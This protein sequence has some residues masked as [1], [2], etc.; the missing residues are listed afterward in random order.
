M[1]KMAKT[2]EIGRTE[3]S[4]RNSSMALVSKIIAI[5]L[6]YFAR[7]VFTH[8]LSESYVSI[9]GLFLEIL[10]VLAI[11]ELGIGVSISYSLY[12]PIARGDVEKQKSLMQLYRRVYFGV[13]GLIVVFGGI[14]AAF[15]PRIVSDDIVVDRIY[16]IYFMYLADACL[17]YFLAYRKTIVEA[18]QKSYITVSIQ[19]FSFIIQNAVQMV[20]LFTTK[21]FILYLSIRLICTLAS[22]LTCS[23]YAV[24][25]YP[26]IK[27]KDVTPLS[28]D[29]KDD[30]FKNV[31]AMMVHKIG[32]VVVNNTDNIFLSVL[33]STLAVGSYSNYYLI[34]GSARQAIDQVLQGITASVG[35]LGHTESVEKMKKIF[36]TTFFVNQWLYSLATICMFNVLDEFVGFSFGN[37]YVFSRDI[38]LVLCLVF[39]IKG[40]RQACL[41]F[42]DSMGLFR[43]D[44]MKA[45]AEMIINVVA[46]L[47]LGKMFGTIGVFIGTIICT[48]TTSTWVEPYVLYKHKLKEGLAGYYLKWILY[49]GIMLA[50]LF[51][52]AKIC[53]LISLGGFGGIIIK[54]ILSFAITN[55]VFLL[56]YSKTREF[57]YCMTKAKGLVKTIFN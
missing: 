28:Q 6:G 9:S 53:Q 7:V 14:I 26:F 17:S 11:S 15:L 27:D 24:K 19:T 21:N 32:N 8:T 33:V 2:R 18:H 48:L 54:A 25:N 23:R 56:V 40:M 3:Y 34:I 31:K 1:C 47:I 52:T 36:N 13:I 4:A 45:V 37:T 29:E 46:S 49:T 30:I 41:I 12:G 39:Y 10:N 42:R 43:Y 57:S 22:N 35:N 5:L 16:L 55:L 38:T 20:V 50:T 51:T 44:W